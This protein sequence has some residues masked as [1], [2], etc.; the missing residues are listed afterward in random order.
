[1]L[2]DGSTG[3]QAGDSLGLS[4]QVPEERLI[5]EPTIGLC[6]TCEHMRRVESDRGSVFYRCALADTDPRFAKYPRLP[7]LRCDGF[8]PVESH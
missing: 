1:L 8:Q 7:V 2:F 3:L 6:A 5:S 4:P